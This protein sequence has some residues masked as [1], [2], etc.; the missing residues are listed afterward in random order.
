MSSAYIAVVAGS[1]NDDRPGSA[2]LS[3]YTSK[4]SRRGRC[5]YQSAQVLSVHV[6]LNCSRVQAAL[7]LTYVQA[8]DLSHAADRTEATRCC[9]ADASC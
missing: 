4:F 7:S 8:G 5:H 2:P 1:D 6:L 9:G 3:H